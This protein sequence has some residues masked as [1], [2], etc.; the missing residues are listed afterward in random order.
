MTQAGKKKKKKSKSRKRHNSSW[1]CTR[2]QPRPHTELRLPHP[3]ARAPARWGPEWA[4]RPST[5]LGPADPSPGFAG[6]M[7][8]KG[9]CRVGLARRALPEGPG[10]QNRRPG[11]GTAKR[12]AVR[13]PQPRARRTVHACQAAAQVLLPSAR[14]GASRGSAGTGRG[15]GGTHPWW[16]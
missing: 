7:P 16:R 1:A 13:S 9:S 5:G 4:A 6:R 8:G 2:L 3:Q 11:R 14:G 10:S 12:R 15:G